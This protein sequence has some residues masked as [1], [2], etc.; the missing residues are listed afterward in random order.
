[1]EKNQRFGP[2]LNFGEEGLTEMSGPWTSN[3]DRQQSQ[4]ATWKSFRTESSTSRAMK[5][6]RAALRLRGGSS[7]SDNSSYSS[8]EIQEEVDPGQPTLIGRFWEAAESN[9]LK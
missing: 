9:T 8:Q 6:Y 1:L 7:E 3:E 2:F 5:K 4:D